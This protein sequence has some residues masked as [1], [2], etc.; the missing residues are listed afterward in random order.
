MSGWVL[1]EEM[2]DKAVD[3]RAPLPRF[4]MYGRLKQGLRW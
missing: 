4:Q 3:S 1:V 2:D